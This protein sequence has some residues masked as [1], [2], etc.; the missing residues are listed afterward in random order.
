MLQNLWTKNHADLLEMST[1]QGLLYFLPRVLVLPFI[2]LFYFFCPCLP[3]F[4]YW[5]SPMMK[6]LG[7]L[8]SYCL[9][10]ALLLV[11]IIK[12]EDRSGVRVPD[13]NS[14][15]DV[16]V[17]I[18]IIGYLVDEVK[19]I[20][21]GG[22]KVY[23]KNWWLLYRAV[24]NLIF[25][26][27][28]ITRMT[29]VA[30]AKDEGP[31]YKAVP[32]YLWPWNEPMLVGESLYCIATVLA[33]IRILYIFQISQ[34]LGPLQLSLSRMISDILQMFIIFFVMIFAFATG[35]TRLYIYYADSKRVDGDGELVEQQEAFTR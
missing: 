26:A 5:A 22:L 16:I 12:G 18:W 19:T 1:L 14:P 27:A 25:L 20:Y 30:I 21:S 32:R 15:V 35:L 13:L 6:F 3:C 28:F 10:L 9:F 8:V 7:D 31:M 11:S 24:M 4:D 23:T 2:Y 17:W 33:F 34:I 29:N